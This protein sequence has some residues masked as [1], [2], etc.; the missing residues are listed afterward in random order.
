[1]FLFRLEEMET[2][3][4]IILNSFD[5]LDIAIE[6]Y[7]LLSVKGNKMLNI[8]CDY[9]VHKK[10]YQLAIKFINY[11]VDYNFHNAVIFNSIGNNLDTLK[12]IAPL[13]QKNPHVFCPIYQE[14]YSL[15]QLKRYD[16]AEKL[17]KSL[18]QM[19]PESFEAWL[20]LIEIYFYSKNYESALITLNIAPI[21]QKKAYNNGFNF[22][23]EDKLLENG[24]ITEPKE[25]GDSDY[26]Y[27]N[28][29]VEQPDFRYTKLND[30][31]KYIQ[32]D[33]IEE[34]KKQE[35]GLNTLPALKLHNHELRLYQI[36]VKSKGK[37]L[38]RNFY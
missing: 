33:Y 1:M 14:A 31:Y 35:E 28:L 5:S 32:Q 11:L 36:L 26:F 15:M 3:F 2:F 34:N 37:S 23:N 22:Q 6:P 8:I 19:I 4:Q 16:L 21:T 27:F 10:R 24:F 20:L 25:K 18:I 30:E 9:L 12:L 29:D 13:L 38:E 17:A 7:E